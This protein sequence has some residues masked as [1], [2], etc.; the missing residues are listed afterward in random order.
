M[1]E[2]DEDDCIVFAF[3]QKTCPSWPIRVTGQQGLWRY[4]KPIETEEGWT[5]VDVIGPFFPGSPS[6]AVGHSRI[7]HLDT[8]KYAGKTARPVDVLHPETI[9]ISNNAKNHSRR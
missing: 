3:N 7:L 1:A 9:A 5:H 2:I 4:V 6:R 8:I